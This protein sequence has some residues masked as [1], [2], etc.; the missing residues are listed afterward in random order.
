VER[1]ADWVGIIDRGMLMVN[2]KIEDLQHRFRQVEVTLSEVL[3]L[4]VSFPKEWLMPEQKERAVR[5]IDTQYEEG[6]SEKRIQ[7]ILP[8][9]MDIVV[10]GMSLREIFVVLAKQFKQS[11]S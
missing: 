1:L 4:P 5:F 11:N 2:E 6:I 8:R 10:Q 3:S 9:C 7:S